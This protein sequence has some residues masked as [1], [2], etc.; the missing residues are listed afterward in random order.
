[1]HIVLQF[2]I[3]ARRHLGC[4]LANNGF[5][6]GDSLADDFLVPMNQQIFFAVKDALK[7]RLIENLM[8]ANHAVLV[9]NALHP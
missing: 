3:K 2:A 1:M 9:G 7:H 5:A 8:R 6:L 4:G